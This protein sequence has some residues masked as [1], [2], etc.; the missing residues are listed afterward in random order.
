MGKHNDFGK[1]GEQIAVDF[2]INKGYKILARNYRYQRAEI[3]IIAEK[4][5]I[6]SVMEVKSR[7]HGFLEDITAAINRKKIGLLTLATNQFVVEND[8]DVE[9]RFDILLVVKEK[10]RYTVEHLE[11]AFYHF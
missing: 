10:E 11:N 4:D 1:R 8:L 5:G 6:L 2:L 7:T 3:D 9:V